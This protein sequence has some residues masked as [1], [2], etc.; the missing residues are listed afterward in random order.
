MMY[1]LQP[2]RVYI[3]D[4]INVFCKGIC[5]CSLMEH[6]N[7]ILYLGSFVMDH[8]GANP[9]LLQGKPLLFGT[10][11]GAIGTFYLLVYYWHI[12]S[13]LLV[14]CWYIISILLVYCWYYYY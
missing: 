14:Y 4:N 2:S 13:I 6:F 1:M 9:S 3:G 7:I 12:I 11:H 10:V 8:P 5:H